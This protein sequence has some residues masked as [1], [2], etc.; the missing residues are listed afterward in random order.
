MVTMSERLKIARITSTELGYLRHLTT[1]SSGRS[2]GLWE[3][4]ELFFGLVWHSIF[5]SFHYRGIYLELVCNYK[6][7]C[8]KPKN[9]KLDW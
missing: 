1:P 4:L 3:L 6:R 7:E 8:G 2:I 5:D 9:I